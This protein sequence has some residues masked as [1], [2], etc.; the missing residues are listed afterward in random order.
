MKRGRHNAQG[1]A[2]R[3][4]HKERSPVK[5]KRLTR[6]RVACKV[7]VGNVDMNEGKGDAQQ[8]L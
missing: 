6:V 3:R 7:V 8:L 5:K 2:T 1:E 4:G